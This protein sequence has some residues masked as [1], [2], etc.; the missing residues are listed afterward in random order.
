MTEDLQY[1]KLSKIC[2][3][4]LWLM[5]QVTFSL[6]WCLKY[7]TTNLYIYKKKK[8]TKQ[9]YAFNVFLTTELLQSFLFSSLSGRF[10]EKGS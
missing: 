1:Q 4:F 5:S 10:C 6:L 7:S 9:F 8:I 3:R 2:K